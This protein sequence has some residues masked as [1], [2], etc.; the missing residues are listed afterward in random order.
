MAKKKLITVMLFLY[1]L[2]VGCESSPSP[3]SDTTSSISPDTVSPSEKVL[4]KSRQFTVK[5]FVE[6][7]SGSGVIFKREKDVYY[8]LTTG[9]NFLLYRNTMN[10]D[11]AGIKSEPDK[12][13]SGDSVNF[14]I[15]TVDGQLHKLMFSEVLQ[16][17]DMDISIF[18]FTSNKEYDV[19]KLSETFQPGQKTYLFGYKNCIQQ[20]DNKVAKFDKTSEFTEGTI[21]NIT[22]EL[23]TKPREYEI[24]Y[25][26]ASIVGMS[27][28][29]LL[30][31]QGEVIAIHGFSGTNK[32]KT[33][34]GALQ[35]CDKLTSTFGGENGNWGIPVKK[36]LEKVEV[37]LKSKDGA[38]VQ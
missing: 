24:G 7:G 18:K 37:V 8:V 36:F 15:V 25:T 17:P 3:S 20:Q 6:K 28:S 9:H 10:E 11:E 19:A 14:S 2:L 31:D 13:K 12:S 27:G 33:S 38:S 4:T 22:K 16:I 5:I 34:E 35:K 29:P 26:N 21:A 1:Q 32:S 23:P 30:N